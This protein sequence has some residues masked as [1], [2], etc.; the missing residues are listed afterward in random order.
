MVRDVPQARNGARPARDVVGDLVALVGER[1]LGPGDRLPPELE[2]ARLLGVGRS[3]LRETL[4]AW[5]QMGIVSRNKG[6]GTVLAAPIGGRTLALPL[7]VTIE[8]ESLLRTLAVRRPLEIEAVRLAARGAT[9]AA[10]DQITAR[11]LHLMAVFYA[12]EDW[13]R[14]D[15]AFHAAIHDATGNPLFGQ[16]I[17]Q[18]QR[19]FLEVYEAPFG[20][21]QLGSETIPLHRDLGEAV[22]GGD[23]E[24]GVAL[25]TRI[26]DDTE[27]AARRVAEETA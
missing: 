23:E 27:A 2:L 22:V 1:G 6:A 17:G 10:R 19:A 18:L 3:K 15:H 12:G 4:V 14:A 5:Q 20:T 21:P 8:M 7:A 9:P 24:A 11:M 13:R 16:L 25:I 26:L